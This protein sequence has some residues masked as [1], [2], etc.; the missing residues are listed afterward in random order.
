MLFKVYKKKKDKANRK[1]KKQ[2]K[3][4]FQDL[5]NDNY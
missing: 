4:H 2:E 3:T 1:R 5:F